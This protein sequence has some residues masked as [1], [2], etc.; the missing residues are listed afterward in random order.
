MKESHGL[1]LFSLLSLP[2]E[3]HR[4]FCAFDQNGHKCIFGICKYTVVSQ[5]VILHRFGEMSV[6]LFVRDW[7]LLYLAVSIITF[8]YLWCNDFMLSSVIVSWTFTLLAEF[9]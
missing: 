6:I 4:L 7:T 2:T 3:D 1:V 5:S 9:L 8:I